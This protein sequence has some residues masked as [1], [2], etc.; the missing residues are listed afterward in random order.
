M[1]PKVKDVSDFITAG[2]TVQELFKL[3]ENTPVYA[4]SPQLPTPRG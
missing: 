1:N 2:H 4:I 3:A